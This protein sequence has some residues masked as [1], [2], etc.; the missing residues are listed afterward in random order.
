ML[1]ALVGAAE[2]GMGSKDCIGGGGRAVP[3]EVLRDLV[4]DMRGPLVAATGFLRLLEGADSAPARGRYTAALKESI[5]A[6]NQILD[7]AR[8]IY[9]GMN[10]K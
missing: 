9:G 8:E 7:D 6:M 10:R 2:A 5:E 1:T 4:H 3:V